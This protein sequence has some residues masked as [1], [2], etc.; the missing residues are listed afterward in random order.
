MTHLLCLFVLLRRGFTM[1]RTRNIK[2][3][4]E[5]SPKEE[6]PIETP[7]KKEKAPKTKDKEKSSKKQGEEQTRGGKK[8]EVIHVYETDEVCLA[9][10]KGQL[11]DAKVWK[12]KPPV[13]AVFFWGG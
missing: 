7:S 10:D 3:E 9:R 11:Y 6:E 8:E 5:E 12:T 2:P 4:T 1:G 13:G